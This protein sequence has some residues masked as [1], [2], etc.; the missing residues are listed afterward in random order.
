MNHIRPHR[1][2]HMVE[3][4]DRG[5][6]TWLPTKDWAMSTL[7]ISVL[8]ALLKAIRPR[9]LFEIGTYIGESTRIFAANMEG[10][11][12]KVFTLDLEKTA[13]VV[14]EGRD[15]AIAEK[16]VAAT[17]PFTDPVYADR[18]QQLLGDSMY[19][20][21]AGFAGQMQYVFIDG[22]HNVEY[23]QK[24]TENALL[25]LDKNSPSVIVWHDYGNPH[26]PD[27]TRYLDDL[28]QEMPLCHVEETMLVFY[29][30]G[31]EGGPL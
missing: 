14:F 26:H 4:Q 9:K 30:N 6:Y 12:S 22:N 31:L 27:L 3:P 2:F 18:I 10:A 7:E 17:R 13:G 28:S 8:V 11:N 20:D 19:F 5:F 21:A 23:V 16:A 1:V 25:M 29:V 15:E 24:D